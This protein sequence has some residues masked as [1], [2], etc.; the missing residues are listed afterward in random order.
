MSI[1]E[2]RE[3]I[4][5]DENTVEVKD[6]FEET[7][8]EL[9]EFDNQCWNKGTGYKIPGFPEVEKRLDGLDAGLFIFAGESNSGKTA[10]MVNM[11]F[12]ICTERSNNLFG[13][14]Y[15][16][17]DS[18]QEVIPRIIA[19][20][21][22]IPIAVASKP[23]RY[24][25]LIDE[26]S[27]DAFVYQGY[28]DKRQDGINHLK[29]LKDVFKIVDSTTIKNA[30]QLYD[31]IKKV[32]IYLKAFD[33]TKKLIVAIDSLSDV[34]FASKGFK[35]ESERNAE[36]AK[37]VKEWSVEFNIPIFGSCHLRKLNANR[38]PSLDDL[39]ESV[40]YV[41]E[42]SL[43][44]LVYNDVSKNKQSASIYYNNDGDSDK[45]PIIELDWAK[46][47]KSS[48]KGRTFSCFIP[49]QSKL[50]EIPETQSTR[51]NALIYQS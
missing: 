21:K 49:D 12:N 51:F 9:D 20:D 38:R 26:I 46:N 28:L 15:S 17:D 50:V 13:I 6:F 43:V 47:K 33:E 42:A 35:S 41:Y 16:L 34:R 19:M 48:Y 45:K 29:E 2:E 39:K 36:V 11:L 5:K 25:A 1:K 4:S 24:K 31:H 37:T 32:Q 23:A 30:E 27:E 22:E 8:E 18:K 7:E 44:W 10:T 3:I 40:E 14:Y